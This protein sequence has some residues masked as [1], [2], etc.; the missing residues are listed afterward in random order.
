M[1]FDSSVEFEY[2]SWRNDWLWF[3]KRCLKECSVSPIYL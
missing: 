3:V 2:F 1:S